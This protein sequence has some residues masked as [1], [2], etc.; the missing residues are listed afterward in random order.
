[1]KRKNISRL[2][3]RIWAG[4]LAF[5]M[6]ASSLPAM[7]VQA[8]T[9]IEVDGTTDVFKAVTTG[10]VVEMPTKDSVK[11]ATFN[12]AAMQQPDEE[13]MTAI[14]NQ[15][16]SKDI[17]FAGLQEVDMNTGRNNYE[18]LEFFHGETYTDVSFQKTID[19][20][21]GEYG[22]GTIS[23][24]AIQE[25]TGGQLITPS[26]QEQ[27]CWQRSLVEV[28]G[29]EIAFYNTHL[30]YDP[31][32]AV[33]AQVQE[34]IA[35]MDADP[36][37]YIVLVGDFNVD[38][39]KEILY[40]FLENYN[41]A[42]GKD[43]VWYDTYNSEIGLLN[44]YA[45]DNIVT[46]RNIEVKSVNHEDNELSDHDMLWVECALL[47]EEVVSTQ[48]LDI[49]VEEASAIDGSL[50]YEDTYAPV[51]EA[52]AAAEALTE[53]ATQEDVN[54]VAASLADSLDG[55]VA[56]PAEGTNLAYGKVAKA[57]TYNITD[58]TFNYMWT[59]PTYPASFEIDLGEVCAVEKMVAFP[60]NDG[61][62]YYNYTIEVSEDGVNYTQV[63]EK[64]D[65]T[66]E[67]AEGTTYE[68][69]DAVNARYVRV[70]MTYN[71]AN[72]AVHMKEFEIYA[73]DAESG[74]LVNVAKGLP[75]LATGVTQ[76]TDGNTGNYWDG[77]KY[78]GYFVVDLGYNYPVGKFVAF[79]YNTGS[80]YYNYYV[81]VSEDGENY[82]KVAEKMNTTPEVADG[83]TFEL[84]EAVNARYVK[85]TMTY[86]NDNESVHMKEFQVY[87]YIA[88]EEEPTPEPE[89]PVV[90]PEDAVNV[91]A[92]KNG[93][94]ADADNVTVTGGDKGF[95]NDGTYGNAW[96]AASASY[97]V[98]GWVTL[99][100]KYSVDAVRVVFKEGQTYNFTVYYYNTNTGGYTEL[101]SGSSYNEANAENEKIGHK[102]Y[103]EYIL[104]DPIVTNKIKVTINS[105]ADASVVPAIAEIE[106][107]GTE[108]DASKEP[109]NLALG[110]DAT[111][112]F[113]D[114]GRTPANA[115][116]GHFGTY[117]DGG[118]IG[119]GQWM[120]VDLGEDCKLTELQVTTFHDAGDG[121]HYLYY[122]EVSSDG[123][124]WTK[125][126]DREKTHGTVAAFRGETYTFD[127][128][129]EARYVRV[130]IT[131][132][133]ANGIAHVK[134]LEVWGYPSVIRE[135]IALGKSVSSSNSDYGRNADVIVDGDYSNYWDGGEYP[136]SFMID[137]GAGYFVDLMK[138]YPYN[139]G[140]R[141]YLYTIEYSLDG[142]NF[143]KLFERTA[144][145]GIAYAGETFELDEPV[146]VRFVKVTMT[147]NS[148]NP[149][150]HMKEFEIFGE[151]NPDYVAPVGDSKDPDNIAYGRKVRTHL[152]AQS[153][154]N[155]TD[156]LD[157]TSCT[158]E[159]APA[160]FDIDLEENYDLSEIILNF[161]VSG[162]T[163]YYYTIY[164]SVDG[165]NYD[166]LYQNRDKHAATADGDK[167]VLSEL[168]LENTEYRIVRVY[169]EYAKGS[170]AAQLSEVRIHGTAT[171]ENTGDL[172]TGSIDEVLDIKPFSETEYAA[173]ITK[174]ET[175]ENVYG[176]VERNV[177]TEYRDW[178]TFVVAENTE[179][180]NDYFTIGQDPLTG[181]I[182]I[183]GNDGVS[184]ASGL[185]Y[186]LREFCDCQITEQTAQVNMPEEIAAVAE[187]VR[188]E[189]PYKVRYAFNYC[190]LNYTF[191]YAD[192]DVFVEENDWLALNGVNCVIDL[193]GQEAVW[194]KFLQNFGY[195]FDEA[196][197]WIAGPSYY[198][199]QFMDNM[200]VVGGPVS[201][202]WVTGRLEMARETQRF[203]NSLGMQTVFQGYAGMIPCNFADFQ[204]E[205]EILD[206]G[207][208]CSLPRPD[209]IRTDGDL[210][211]QYA[212]LFYAAQEWA[213]GATS[214][215]YAVD[216]FHEGGI[217]PDDLSDETIAENVLES[218][219]K[220]DSDGIWMVQAWWSNPSVELLRGMGD[221]RQ[222]HVIILDLTGVGGSKWDTLTYGSTTL[223]TIE[224]NGTDWV[225]CLLD[226]YGGNPS[227]DGN[228]QLV[229][230]EITNARDTAEHMKGIGIIPEAT[231]MNPVLYQIMFDMTWAAEGTVD[232][233]EWL[234]DYVIDRY[235]AESE[236][237]REAWDLLKQTVYSREGHTSQVMA[238]T[239]PSLTKYGLPYS[240]VKAEKAL[241]LLFEDFE[242]L[243]NSESYLYDLS[244]LMRQV[245][246]NYAVVELG[247]MKT[248]YESGDLETFRALKEK[249][250]S[251]FD[252][253]ELVL[254]TQKD[255]MAGNW[256]GGA[257]DWAINTGADDFAYDSMVINAK[258]IIT[259]WAP[260]S[261]LG[262]Y[263]YR[264]YQGMF[265][266]IYKPL[267]QNFL[268][269]QEDIL[270]TGSTDLE[271]IGYTNTCM[272]WIYADQDYNRVADNSPENM[273]YVV[274]RVIEECN[275]DT[276]LPEYPENEGNIALGK[277]VAAT[278]E[279]PDSPGAPGGGY[280]EHITDG[281][282]ETYW[283]GIE[284]AYA[285]EAVIDLEAEYTI[286]KIN[287]LCY[288]AGSRYYLY[289]IY[290]SVDGQEWTQILNKTATDAGTDAGDD[291]TFEDVTA[292]Y[293]KIVGTYNSSNEGFHVKEVRVYG[294][295]TPETP[296]VVVPVDKSGLQTMV[297]DA[298]AGDY[299]SKTEESVAVLKAA[300]EAAEI[301]LADDEATQEEV[302]NAKAAIE[303][304]V[305]GLQDKP[306]EPEMIDP[307]DDSLDVPVE[308]YTAT[309]GSTQPG[310]SPD[311][312]LDGD[313]SSFWEVVWDI[314]NEDP[315]VLW[316][317]ITLDDVV[318]VQAVRYLPRWGGAAGNI[319]GLITQYYVTV[320]EDGSEWSTVA[321]GTWDR[322]EGWK[323]AQ[324]EEPVNA[325]Y[326]RLV[327]EGTWADVGENSNMSIAEIRVKATGEV[328]NK[329][330]LKAAIADAKEVAQ[331]LYTSATAKAL[332]NAIAAGEALV[333]DETAT[334]EAVDEAAEAIAKAKAA[335]VAKATAEEKAVLEKA[336]D[337]AE[338]MDTSTYTEESVAVLADAIAAAKA[339]LDDADATSKGVKDAADDL[340][341]AV[342]A[343]EIP[344]VEDEVVRLFGQGRYD[345]AYAVADAL[346]EALGVEKFEAAV[347]ATG[348]NFADAL[349][350]SYLAVEKNAPI[351]LTNGKDDNIAQLHAYIKENIA[352]GGKVFILGGDGAVPTSVDEIDG[353]DVVR[354]FGE[355]RYDTNL[356]ILEEAG[357]S[358]D[359]IIVA[360][361][362]TFADSLSASAAKLPILLV[363]PDATL[364]DAQ[365]AVLEGMKN[366][367]IVGGDGA[368]SAEYE[369]ELAA[370]GEVT[371]VFGE[372]RYDTSV[373]VAKTF[374][375]DV[376][377]AVVASGKNFPDG[378]CGGPLAAA[379]N[380]PLVLTKDGEVA[381]A[382]AYVAE[383]GIASG[384]V[385][386]GDGALADETVV[387]VFT[388]ESAA[389]IK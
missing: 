294:E 118:T 121:R 114:W 271:A 151:L 273:K 178:F 340:Q 264:N 284:W 346:K 48:Y 297:E 248:A 383:N 254:G 319:N 246:N 233:D 249:F 352:E 291:F 260:S 277:K 104:D 163:Y 202:E 50:Y 182:V 147:Y 388:L 186:Y 85:V 342:D 250:L 283:D 351:L 325:K 21:D 266:D 191:S 353:Y 170:S 28:D 341:D 102:Y 92:Y 58:G 241:A 293:I 227:M 237:A 261:Y 365:K 238:S 125:V 67:V 11:F 192:Y 175:I 66:P 282:P 64:A 20:D 375:K 299:S 47:D 228:L 343:L 157:V 72:V 138:A 322:V 1:M 363:K 219:L 357:V 324:F 256:I 312:A 258:T 213:F 303:E 156:G 168:G 45:I 99:D 311:I 292:R 38:E 116:D 208:W 367:Y 52:L 323:L 17:D 171:G 93:G 3:K 62:R 240:T 35:M 25:K 300:I 144:D 310:N 153:V 317:Q 309:A 384:Y 90:I 381:A 203:K 224:F 51:A 255:L 197:D 358:G 6:A 274:G 332:A 150:V 109:R 65:S 344:V 374:C 359:S 244:E 172:R 270:E 19:F 221:Y 368:V 209:M 234:D 78:P 174:D 278:H 223:D 362:K 56:I 370:F 103:S 98:S 126:A 34:L 111:A 49:L 242:T 263:A 305:L 360:T 195:S 345:T 205:V 366:I 112:S 251:S 347:V 206:Q 196:K 230:N 77:G 106:A 301:V 189:T 253:L 127:E 177:G 145:M 338:A 14:L 267:W 161:P 149:S 39:S 281:R 252:L 373:E 162:D 275:T 159:F 81:E 158:G 142:H 122:V 31:R 124:N 148:S 27:R 218:L 185:H 70:N 272:E 60:Y 160:Y 382:A 165:S 4:A 137:L 83:T 225:C 371:R 198:A 33:E 286:D 222:D 376:T 36:T 97:P 377:K 167:I 94:S 386:G 100:G 318:E 113:V 231:Y 327:A 155:I 372:S 201:D 91:A 232:L 41:L 245:V 216:P 304:A 176:I 354:L 379:L 15:L 184:L 314:G 302:D 369:A 123:E 289:D 288:V 280:A 86:N 68:F 129:I 120:M 101:Y 146:E 220:Y 22:F 361:G 210:Y 80:R 13:N 334:Q 187:P 135:N 276:P 53:D 215:Y 143:T 7:S 154:A 108:Y 315:S 44:N 308:M 355:T 74:E 140:V 115:L 204:P 164:G 268:D 306:V 5:V 152:A 336:V 364:S 257:E 326:I 226:N 166:R 40:P 173:P 82:T 181:K 110:A 61:S 389:E 380:A 316:Y 290:S 285:P 105:G 96:V 54:A 12:I 73:A 59:G 16:E 243:C 8:E 330:A 207:T 296:E 46:S 287:V 235:G 262:A 180:D 335:L 179:N 43:G 259:V 348:T 269:R 29:K 385:L 139:D 265:D 236:S 331:E 387:E 356:A 183:T 321:E 194:I 200:E 63:A 328:I 130:T 75:A 239:S 333:D 95:L 298:K 349:A 199:W 169:M 10:S 136:Q 229:I 247:N 107:F 295:E 190:T 350:G 71:S 23:K 329:G 132:N 69:A 117:W 131:K 212:E 89:D 279:R 133:S 18:M 128:V 32:S 24:T 57:T 55:L 42:N 217:R 193:A 337:V 30:S 9:S 87:P 134:E 88:S 26:G 211:D 214:D 76:I 37:E 79:P 2:C 188:C 378:I 339:V 119:D 84:E 141:H 307:A 320:S 313:P